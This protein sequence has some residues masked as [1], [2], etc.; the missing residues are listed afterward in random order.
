[1]VQWVKDLALSRLWL[2]FDPGPETQAPDMKQTQPKII[3]IENY[4]PKRVCGWASGPSRAP[5]TQKKKK[6]ITHRLSLLPY[7]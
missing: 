3:I 5:P 1:M 7:A 4:Y 6:K 2:G